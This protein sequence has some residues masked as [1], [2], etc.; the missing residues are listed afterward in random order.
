MTFVQNLLAALAALGIF[1]M[2]AGAQAPK[3]SPAPVP[4]PSQLPPQSPAAPTS[5]GAI[6]IQY[7]LD[8]LDKDRDGFVSRSEAAGVPDLLKIFSKLDRNRDGKLDE[9]ELTEHNKQALGAK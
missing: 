7:K 1:A 6:V 4:P 8:L 3:P 9:G 2:S 5:P